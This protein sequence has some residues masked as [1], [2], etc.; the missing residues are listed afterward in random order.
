MRKKKKPMKLKILPIAIALGIVAVI[1]VTIML[2]TILSQNYIIQENIKATNI[3]DNIDVSKANVIIINEL[4]IGGLQDN[5]WIPAEKI[6]DANIV[7]DGISVDMFSKTA[8]YGTFETASLK[9]NKKSNIVYTTTTKTP[10]PEEYI[11]ISATNDYKNSYLKATATQDSDIKAV[12][13]ALG[14]YRL[15]NNTIKII[16]SYDAYIKQNMPGRIIV[17]TSESNFFGVYSAIIYSDLDG[18][19]IVKYAYVKNS[20]KSVSWPIYAA[21]FA[22]DLDNDGISELIIQ[23]TTETTT[24]YTIMKYEDGVFYE[25]LKHTVNL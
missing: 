9:Y 19:S 22:I 4:L 25:V 5:K 20:E 1:A 13:K 10:T 15:F 17:V 24:S 6:Y 7:G 3:E 14:K 12:K 18:S 16:A 2:I 23:E 21:N 8:K 11:A